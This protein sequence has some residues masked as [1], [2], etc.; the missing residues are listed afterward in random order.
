[1]PK[2][3]KETNQIWIKLLGLPPCCFI[4]KQSAVRHITYYSQIPTDDEWEMTTCDNLNNSSILV[5]STISFKY[6]KKAM[7]ITL[8]TWKRRPF[9][10]NRQLRMI[11]FSNAIMHIFLCVVL[12]CGALAD[13]RASVTQS[14]NGGFKGD[15]TV[16]GELHD[17]RV[18][19]KFDRPVNNVEVNKDSHI[20]ESQRK[21]RTNIFRKVLLGYN[22]QILIP[23]VQC[24]N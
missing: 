21:K 17:W 15:I 3:W 7:L 10:Y 12:F 13:N 5:N 1:V 11:S 19:L 14:W 23:D 2:N 18:H 6:E 22:N 8:I 24:V 9:I 20:S 16:H 4:A